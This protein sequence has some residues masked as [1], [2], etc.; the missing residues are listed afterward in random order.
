MSEPT[1]CPYDNR[2]DV[3]VFDHNDDNYEENH[4]EWWLC[5]RCQ[6]PFTYV[7]PKK[8]KPLPWQIQ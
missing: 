2:H 4:I 5:Q 7:P 8:G 6:K 3:V 1:K